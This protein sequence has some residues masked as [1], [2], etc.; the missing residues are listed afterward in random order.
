NESDRLWRALFVVAAAVEPV[1]VHRL[2]ETKDDFEIALGEPCQHLPPPSLDPFEE[3][4]ELAQGGGDQGDEQAAAIGGIGLPA[5]VAGFLQTIQ[6]DRDATAAETRH[7]AE[8]TRRRWPVEL[9]RMNHLKVGRTE[10]DFLR[11]LRIEEVRRGD[12]LAH[13]QDDAVLKRDLRARAGR[14]RFGDC[15]PR[16]NPLREWHWRR[17]LTYVQS[18]LLYKRH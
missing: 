1:G 10:A 16:S 18:I 5:N 12:E 17:S 2:E 8:S 15:R 9:Q 11:C 14:V 4:P 7:R 3:A 13:L 6:R